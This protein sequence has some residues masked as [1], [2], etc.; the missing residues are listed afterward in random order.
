[1]QRINIIDKCEFS[2][3]CYIFIPTSHS[4]PDFCE[5][6]V[7]FF[8]L[9]SS[10]DTLMESK[11]KYRHKRD[12]LDTIEVLMRTSQTSFASKT[13]IPLRDES[14][15]PVQFGE[16]FA[17]PRRVRRRASRR[18]HRVLPCHVMCRAL[19][20]FSIRSLSLSNETSGS[21]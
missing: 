17:V 16:R 12:S 19:I 11:G 10:T 3:I 5:V 18:C 8:S 6:D 2:L 1:M 7:T 21:Q 4:A 9:L 20:A 15:G 13:K 14:H